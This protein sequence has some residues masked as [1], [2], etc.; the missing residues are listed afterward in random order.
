MKVFISWSGP[1][2]HRVALALHAW[3]PLVLPRAV[4]FVSSEDIDK[5]A[6]WGPALTAELDATRFGIICLFPENLRS[7]WVIF[8][9]GAISQSQSMEKARVA[10]LLVGVATKDVPGPLAQFQCT[11]FEKADVRK[12]VHSI[13]RASD[14][15]VDA[16]QL[17]EAF[18]RHWPQLEGVVRG[19]EKK[20][21]PRGGLVREALPAAPPEDTAEG[22]VGLPLAKNPDTYPTADELAQRISEQRTKTDY[23]L[24][25]LRQ[26]RFINYRLVVGEPAEYYLT[27]EGTAYVVENDLI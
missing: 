27:E 1:R 10:P 9:A 23:H 25:R 4:P 3:L 2:S 20:S 5:G 22:P 17:D 21:Q 6:R 13:N 26:H 8:E 16:R 14:E 11:A 15:Q 24:N 12:L 18:E 19:L 7:D